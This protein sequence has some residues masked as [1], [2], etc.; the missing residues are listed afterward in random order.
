MSAP[1]LPPG[2]S[3]LPEALLPYQ[4]QLLQATARS[5]VV[6]CEK[7]RRIGM[8]WGIGAD[9]VLTAA[10]KRGQG[11][12]DV[13][14][15]GFNLDM[16][17]EFIDTCAMWARAFVPASSEVSEFIFIDQ[18]QGHVDR[19]IQAFRITFASGFE[20]VALCSRPRAV[21]GRQGYVI[22][23]EAAFHDELDELLKAAL[24]L[25][26]WG[27]KV[28]IISTHDGIEN[29]FAQLVDD[30]RAGRRKYELLRVT[31]AD[32]LADGLFRRVCL[33]SGREW[34]PAAELEW[35]NGIRDFYGDGAGE[36][37]DAV[38][39]ASS[40]R[41]L[42]RALLERQGRD[43]PVLELALEE[44]F[45]DLP[46]HERD[47]RIDTWLDEHVAPLIVA[48]SPE[49]RSSVGVDFARSQ[50]ATVFWPLGSRDTR[51]STP[52]LLELRRVPFTS[53]ARALHW[54]CDRLPRFSGAAVD[55]RGNGQYLAEVTRQRY[56]AHCVAEVMI[57]DAW[58]REHVPPMRA[59]LEDDTLSIPRDEDVL[60][61]FRALGLV[62]GVPRVTGHTKGRGG[63]RH[64][65]SAIAC[66]LALQAH[67][68]IDAGPV[69]FAAGPA[70]ESN[71]AWG[72]AHPAFAGWGR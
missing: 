16:T 70:L 13:F 14:Y 25:L 52:F 43:V 29:P 24:A 35:A 60:G 27:G 67:R 62:N 26:I 64:G 41:Y 59:A 66:A 46:E 63:Q 12:Q 10:A 36:E 39:R 50:D 22:I 45:V 11:G 5:Q 37:L 31:F 7:S 55:A 18:A 1:Q 2:A 3:S 51:S 30:C 33:V 61:D 21:R 65:D 28:L 44:T 20:I 6:V 68:T 32:A 19:H 23:D 53:Q 49:A 40:G 15:I 56:G 47:A 38:P 34:S 72:G 17:R 71:A 8:T 69:T 42:A 9:A 57:S 58:Y 48:L 4:V 54:L